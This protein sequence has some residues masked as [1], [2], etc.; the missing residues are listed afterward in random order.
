M[1]AW[2]GW[3]LTRFPTWFVF[4]L[5]FATLTPALTMRRCLEVCACLLS[6]NVLVYNK[7]LTTICLP[8][9]CCRRCVSMLAAIILGTCPLS[10]SGALYRNFVRG[11]PKRIF[12]ARRLDI[13]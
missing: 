5:S 10:V 7:N 12:Y 8:S 6:I 2:G 1:V 3:I 11:A 9:G 4:L 13:L